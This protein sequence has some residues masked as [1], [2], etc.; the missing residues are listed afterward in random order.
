MSSDGYAQWKGWRDESFGVFTREQARYFKVELGRCGF[1]D[2]AGICILEYG[3]GNGE[4][5]A[6]SVQLGAIYRGIEAIDDLISRGRAL[7]YDVYHVDEFAVDDVCPA[8]VDLVIAFDVLEHLSA[9]VLQKRLGDI[10]RALKPG[11]RLLAR[12]PSGDSPFSGAIQYGD[13][14]HRTRLGSSA[15]HQLASRTG[16]VVEQCREPSFPVTGLGL[17]RL[18]RRGLIALTRRLGHFLIARIFMGGGAPI[19]T[20]NMIFV[21]QKRRCPDDV[22]P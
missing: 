4:F 8:T 17:S 14:T 10:E 11:G 22:E 7:G 9:R 1:R 13:L 18:V 15:V 19:L 6:W 2:L 3:F 16:L 21:L 5:A 20:P 12:V